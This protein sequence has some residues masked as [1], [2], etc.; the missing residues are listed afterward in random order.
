MGLVFGKSFLKRASSLCLVCQKYA[1]HWLTKIPH[2]HLPWVY[3]KFSGF[4]LIEI[5]FVLLIMGIT[6]SITFPFLTASQ[7]LE[8]HKVTESHHDQIFRALAGY[9]LQYRGLPQ[10]STPE[11]AG[12]EGTSCYDQHEPVCVG[13]LPYQEL[14]LS[15]SIARDGYGNWFTYAMAK[16]LV[17]KHMQGNNIAD[18]KWEKKADFCFV[19]VPGIT[20]NSLAGEPLLPQKAKDFIAVVLISHGSKGAGAF[21]PTTSDR[22]PVEHPLEIKNSIDYNDFVMRTSQDT[23]AKFTHEVYWITRNNLMSIYGKYPCQRKDNFLE[24]TLDVVPALPSK[25][26]PKDPIKRDNSGLF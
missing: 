17:S 4:S 18:N 5:A 14:G 6:A 20:L 3:T 26:L 21:H 11:L 22:L 1:S 25:E 9:V 23:D 24:H 19:K 16:G 13:I 15:E 2:L 10:P 8:R 7:K 12:K